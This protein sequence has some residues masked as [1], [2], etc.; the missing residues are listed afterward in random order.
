MHPALWTLFPQPQL[1]VKKSILEA[2]TEMGFPIRKQ[3]KKN[4]P[5]WV[6][7]S[8]KNAR[9]LTN[10]CFGPKSITNHLLRRDSAQLPISLWK[11]VYLMLETM[12]EQMAPLRVEVC[13]QP[14]SQSCPGA[15]QMQ[16]FHR[17]M[18]STARVPSPHFSVGRRPSL[19]SR[20]SRLLCLYLG[21]SWF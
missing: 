7:F 15:V 11:Q 13:G 20:G 21:P 12:G 3:M 8:I 1:C 2:H 16:D 19:A 10:F 5:V 17:R 9:I 6:L 18:P 4:L 14:S